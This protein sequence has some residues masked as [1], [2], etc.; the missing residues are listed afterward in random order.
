MAT[1][2]PNRGRPI[3]LSILGI[4]LLIAAVFTIRRLT[5]TTVEVDIARVS[6]QDLL[7]TI[8]TNGKVEP[9]DGAA[10]QAHAL[11][12]GVVAKVYVD[13]NQYVTP[14]TLLISLRDAD[15]RSRLATAQSSLSAAEVSQQDIGNG[16]SVEELQRFRQDVVA[17]QAD[18]DQ[19]AADLAAEQSLQQK[20]AASAAEVAQKQ[21]RLQTATLTL[22]N[23]Q[24]RLAGRYSPQD[25]AAQSSRVNDARA[26]IAAAQSSIAANE[27][28]S[29]IAGTVYSIPVS[30]YDYVRDGDDLMDVA[31][32]NRIQI[33]AYFDEPEIGKLSPGQAV[34]IAWDAK[35][36]QFWHG[37][38][39]RAPTTVFRYNTRSVGEALISVDDAKG[40]LPPNS[41]VTVTVTISSRSKV[42][43]VPREALHTEG[44]NDFVYRIVKGRL[45]STVVKIGIVSSTDV[46][47]LS[48]LQ[49]NDIIA[50]HATTPGQD[51]A[52]GLVVKQAP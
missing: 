52:N 39:S 3:L 26:A 15:A 13:V 38:I 7:S 43:S 4:L 33:R 19:A 16:G 50:L 12:P 14:G 51:L 20:G 45:K 6:H 22:R 8:S 37:R 30:P 2:A 49:D 31:D 28:R 25:V 29:P 9:V 41:N 40:D 46:E 34:K 36:D 17:A 48:G 5:R 11:G 42:L 44:V 35:R 10:F 24:A 47:I 1:A 23:A 21:Q 27:I 18:H 32:L